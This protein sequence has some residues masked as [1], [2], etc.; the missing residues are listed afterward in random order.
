MSRSSVP[1]AERRLYELWSELYDLSAAEALLE[2]DQE[3]QMPAGGNGSRGE[4][5]ATMAAL[6][7]RRLV[8]N[9]LRDVLASCAELAEADSALAAQVRVARRAVD[10]AVKVPERLMREIAEARSAG[11]AAWQQARGESRFALYEK[12]LARMISAKREEAAAVADGGSLYDALIDAFE[13]DASSA[14][15]AELFGELTAT[16]TPLVRAV[17]ESGVTVDESP[18]F[19]RFPAESQIEL[20]RRAAAAVGY[21]FGAGRIDKSAHPFCIRIHRGDVRMTCRQQEDDFRP[22]LYGILHE[23]GHALYEQGLPE[24]WHRTPLDEAASLGIHESQSL[25]WENHVGRSRGFLRWLAPVFRATFPDAAPVEEDVLWPA[26]HTVRPSLIRVDAD[27]TT[28]NLHIA[29]RFEVERALFGEGEDD[30]EVSDLPAA[31]ND[32]YQ[33]YLGVRPDNDAEGVL[34]DIHWAYGAFGYFP[35]Y[36]LGMLAAAQLFAA[37]RR[38]LGDLDE[39]F[40]AGEF[41]PLL[42]WLRERVHRKGSFLTPDEL[43]EDATG[44]PLDTEDFVAALRRDAATVYGIT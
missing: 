32:R 12:A 28:Y 8:S 15:L 6:K 23:T 39:R 20:G 1:E 24:T 17:A 27:P 3:T 13:P 42:D 36:T 25:L 38:D 10:R 19:G 4:I 2:W 30:L 11:I 33:R 9:E 40:A 35:T 21:D 34:Q 29:I 18:A 43:V 37:A 14:K 41:R 44:R 16:L 5:L 22:G 26:L 31:W 7:H